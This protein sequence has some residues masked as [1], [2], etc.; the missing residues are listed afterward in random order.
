MSNF[1]EQSFLMPLAAF[2]T[3]LI[4]F[5]KPKAQQ[6]K[7]ICFYSMLQQK[8][9]LNTTIKISDL[10]LPDGSPGGTKVLSKI[11]LLYD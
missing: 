3:R 9:Q 4:A 7:I 2:K 5:D 10:V 8:K 6:K 11:P 1:K